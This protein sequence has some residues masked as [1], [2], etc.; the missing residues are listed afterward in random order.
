VRRVARVLE[1]DGVRPEAILVLTFTRTAA[2]DLVSKLASLGSPGADRVVATTIHAFCLRLLQ[3]DAVLAATGR[4]TRILLEHERDLMLRDLRGPFGTIRERRALLWA[5]E[6][7]WAR[8][9]TDHP[10]TTT[11]PTDVSFEGQVLRWLRQHDAM[12]IGEVV[13]IAFQY[14]TAN[15]LLE[16]RTRFEHVLV[17]EYQDLNTLEQALVELLVPPTGSLCVIG[18]D[19]QSIYRFRYAHPEGIQ[20]FVGDPRTEPQSIGDCLRCPTNVVEMATP[21]FLERPGEPGHHFAH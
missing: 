8:R 4:N 6:A 19:D 21:S 1:A 18:D 10:G 17:D 3:Q 20:V 2:Q 14:L 13:P 5:F 7:G 16:E 9:T 15:P 11:S 12:L